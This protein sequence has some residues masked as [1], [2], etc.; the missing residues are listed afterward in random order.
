MA[1]FDVIVIGA[2][3]N[4]L[5]T[6]AIMAKAGRRVLVLERRDVAGGMCAGEEFHP[7]YRSAGLLHDTAQVRSGLV[8]AL[9]LDQYGLEMTPATPVLIP[10]ADGPGVVLSSNDE[11]TA[12]EL[13]RL[14][15]QDANAWRRYRAFVAGA[16]RVIEPLLN[17]IPPDLARIG[18][19]DSGSI[20]TLLKSGMA[21]R[22]LGGEGMNELLRVPPMC[23]AD[24]LNEYFHHDL[25]K[26]GLAHA[27]ILGTWAGPWSPGTAAN[28]LL[29]ECTTGES[30]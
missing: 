25:V 23:V 1:D 10:E 17:E 13:L 22:K 16:R 14:G 5:T 30:V 8:D 20:P 27:A 9:Q 29:L 3:H 18:L 28:L 19:L 4:G 2:G 15:D 12:A 6:A 21:L 26:G 11:A 24:W 7:G